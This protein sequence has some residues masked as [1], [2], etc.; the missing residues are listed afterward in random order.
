MPER[1]ASVATPL[2]PR[3]GRSR[4]VRRQSGS[5]V[6]WTPHGDPRIYALAEDYLQLRRAVGD[7]I[8]AMPAV[9]ATY[10]AHEILSRAHFR[11]SARSEGGEVS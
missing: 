10:E 8:R 11:C 1:W 4:R 7:A 3:N 2:L 6:M 9:S 5:S